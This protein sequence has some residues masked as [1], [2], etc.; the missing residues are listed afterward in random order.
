MLQNM[1]KTCLKLAAVT[2]YNKFMIKIEFNIVTDFRWL[3]F[4]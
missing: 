4:P 2:L 1:V 3:E